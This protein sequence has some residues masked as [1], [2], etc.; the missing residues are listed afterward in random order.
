MNNVV[1]KIT[2]LMQSCI[3]HD[4]YEGI[5]KQDLLLVINDLIEK[6]LLNLWIT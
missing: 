3:A 5:S 6:K 4:I 1:K 2:I